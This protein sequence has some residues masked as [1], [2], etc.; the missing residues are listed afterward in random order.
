VCERPGFWRWLPKVLVEKLR[1]LYKAWIGEPFVECYMGIMATILFLFVAITNF[2]LTLT[3]RSIL[4]LLAVPSF[5]VMMHG[6]YRKGD[7]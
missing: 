4:A 7:Y 5:L 2:N 6:F 3:K 1:W